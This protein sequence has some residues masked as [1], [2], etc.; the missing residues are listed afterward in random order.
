MYG[1]AATAAAAACVQTHNYYQARTQMDLFL[2][3]VVVLFSTIVA[4]GRH[5]LNSQC[6]K[7]N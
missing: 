5:I 1:A 6:T 3:D 7:S 2:I 4:I